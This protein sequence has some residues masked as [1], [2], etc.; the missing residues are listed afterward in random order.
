MIELK[1]GKSYLE[2]EDA[3]NGII[4][5][6]KTLKVIVRGELISDLT[7]IDTLLIKKAPASSLA[8]K[9]KEWECKACAYVNPEKARK[10]KMCQRNARSQSK[11]KARNIDC[12]V[13]K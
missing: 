5:E 3:T 6:G 1:I 11:A 4:L 7:E 9:T 8:S 12:Q 2:K 13:E 10:C